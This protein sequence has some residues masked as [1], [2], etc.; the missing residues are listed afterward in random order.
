MHGTGVYFVEVGLKG[1][2]LHKKKKML[3][4]L[5]FIRHCV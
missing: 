2:A 5:F 4:I 1:P 3:V